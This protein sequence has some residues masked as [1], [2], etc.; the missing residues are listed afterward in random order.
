MQSVSWLS[1]N[2]RHWPFLGNKRFILRGDNIICFA[3][4]TIPEASV[5]YD[6]L[7]LEQFCGDWLATESPAL[8]QA[9]RAQLKIRENNDPAERIYQVQYFKISVN[10]VEIFILNF[11][12]SFKNIHRLFRRHL[13]TAVFIN[14]AVT[15]YLE[16]NY[17]ECLR[18]LRV[19]ECYNNSLIATTQNNNLGLPNVR[20]P[21]GFHFDPLLISN[22]ERLAVMVITYFYQLY[23][24]NMFFITECIRILQKT[25]PVCKW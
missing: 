20:Q 2:K 5:V 16:A 7:L 12:N 8:V 13:E 25:I 18:C 19:A 23:L 14:H 10:F 11:W 1:V 22:L 24:C 15:R 6:R 17:F 4:C 9:A 3:L 21:P